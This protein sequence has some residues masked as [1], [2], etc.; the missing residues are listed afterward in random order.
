MSYN[1]CV[2]YFFQNQNDFEAL[3]L[4]LFEAH[5]SQ[6]EVFIAHFYTNIFKISFWVWQVVP[7]QEL[8]DLLWY[9]LPFKY[10]RIM[11]F[12]WFCLFFLSLDKC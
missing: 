2:K 12:Q 7:I 3:E 1:I 4:V 6:I 9:W 11:V 8:Q 10:I 5:V